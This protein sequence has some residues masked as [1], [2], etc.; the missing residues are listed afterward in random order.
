MVLWQVLRCNLLIADDTLPQKEL[1]SLTVFLLARKCPIE[2]ISCNI[3]KVLLPLLVTLLHRT[4]R[5][6]SPRTVLPIVTR[7]S[8]EVSTTVGISLKIT[9]NYA[10]S[11]P[12][13]PWLYTTKQNPSRTSWCIL[14]KPNQHLYILLSTNLVSDSHWHLCDQYTTL[15]Q[16][17]SP[18]NRHTPFDKGIK[19]N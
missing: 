10:A 8:P 12:A 3:S 2:I 1:D 13:T 18:P 9:H 17:T 15:S 4:P 11:G 16:P 5:V 6:S 14:A 19:V 7:Y